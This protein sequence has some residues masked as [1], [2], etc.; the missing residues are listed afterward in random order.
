MK[1][2]KT[3]ACAAALVCGGSAVSA[4]TFNFAETADTL[5]EG[6]YNDVVGGSWTVDGITLVSVDAYT[7]DGA[8]NASFTLVEDGAYLD[9]STGRKPGGLGACTGGYTA[10]DPRQCSVGD[11]DNVGPSGG[12]SIET[13][14]YEALVLTFDRDVKITD[15]LLRNDDH[16]ILTSG[17][18]LYGTDGAAGPEDV[19]EWMIGIT[20]DTGFS[21]S[22]VFASASGFEDFYIDTMSVS[23]VPVPAAGFLLLGG[24]GGLAAMKRRKKA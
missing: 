24:L 14:L 23:A 10:D 20:A 5:G 18:I 4:A 19:A 17:S 6:A 22:W 2:F 11:D 7:H 3:A 15:I 1:L 13:D 8:T 16:V 12:L 9:E 21:T